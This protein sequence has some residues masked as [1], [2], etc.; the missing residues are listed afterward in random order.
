MFKN[1]NT[2]I[3]SYKSTLELSPRALS[4]G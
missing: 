4:Y 1:E 2:G 3:Y